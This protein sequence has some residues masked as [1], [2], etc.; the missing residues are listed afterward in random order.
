M[1]GGKSTPPPGKSAQPQAPR[2]ILELERFSGATLTRWEAVSKDLDELHASLYFGVMP[3]Q[4]RI[5]GELIAALQKTVCTSLSLARWA[6][7]ITYQYSMEPLSAAGSLQALGGRFNAGMDLDPDTLNPWP[8]LYIAE[9]DRTAFVE[10]F[11]RAPEE[12][13]EGL[14]P[15]ELALTASVSH[16]T[17]Y[18]NCELHRVFDMTSPSSLAAAAKVFGRIKMPAGA[19]RLKKKL[20]L[21]SRAVHMISSGYQ[22]HNAVLAYNWRTTPAQ[23]GLP[24]PSHTL[25]YLVRAAGFEA[26]LYRSTKGTDRCL[27]VFP[28]CLDPGSYVELADAAPGSVQHY[29]LD[30]DSADDLAGWDSLP[31]Q[32]RPR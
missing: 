21:S 26:I 2:G 10:K 19:K 15:Q 11:Q 28:D 18:L 20:N 31:S 3:E 32:K 23:F 1:P 24:A 9:T 29:R 27:A 13:V 30:I 7:I 25:A 6:R 16:S 8:A 14:S 22:L 4:R 12:R 17:V 5:R